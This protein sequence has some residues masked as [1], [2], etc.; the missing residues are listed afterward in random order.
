MDVNSDG[1]KTLLGGGRIYDGSGRGPYVGDVLISG[2][3]ILDVAPSIDCGEAERL[4]V[5]GRDVMPGFIDVHSHDDAALFRPGALDPKLRQGV[6]TTVIGNCGHG[7]APSSSDSSLE[8]YSTPVLGPFPSHRWPTFADYLTDIASA[9]RR[10][11][12]L[13]LVPHA[14]IRSAVVGMMRRA[15]DSGERDRIAGLVRDALDAGAA[16]VSFGLMYSPGNAADATE[17]E[18]IGTAVASRG[19]VVAAHVR[20]E[21][22]HLLPSLEEVAAIARSTGVALHVSHLKVTGPRNVGRMPEVI[23]RLDAYRNEGIDV[24]ADVYP[25][26]AGSTTV[27]T[28]FPSWSTDRGTTSLLAALT[29]AATRSR[30]LDELRAPW[31][32]SPLE[33]YFASLG[34]DAILL[35][36]FRSPDLLAYDG[37]SIATIAAHRG[38]DPAECL[39][40][41]VLAERGALTVV[42]FQTDIEG[43]KAALSW[44]WTLIGSDGLPSES[45]YVHPRLYG[46]FP[47]LLTAFA[48]AGKSISRAEAVKRATCDSARRFGIR[49]RGVIGPGAVADLQVL[50]PHVYADR[51]SFE[52]PRRSPSGLDEVYVRGQRVLTE[53]AGAAFGRLLPATAAG[54]T[55]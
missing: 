18:A 49:D 12:A 15:A 7:C 35:G 11:N 43:M 29:D 8:D 9:P 39:A 26:D 3:R 24:T 25:Y 40:D 16:G 34:P 5:T 37:R 54:A 2:E 31:T 42:L 46:T 6:T 50:D 14:P 22:D 1:G 19:G 47:R 21:A 48:G 10:L 23:D 17:L 41:L 28:L 52:D 45:G 38:Q 13:A 44:P 20:N 4:D 55:L 33:N 30:L 32:G 27:A 36:G 51:S 53:P